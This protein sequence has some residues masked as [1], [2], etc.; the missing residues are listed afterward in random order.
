MTTNFPDSGQ[1][2]EMSDPKN[3]EAEAE[4]SPSSSYLYSGLAEHQRPFRASPTDDAY[5]N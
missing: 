3:F 4:A 2:C 5:C 1:T